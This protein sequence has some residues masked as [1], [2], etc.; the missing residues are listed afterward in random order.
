MLA[1]FVFI[2]YLF[3]ALAIPVTLA[4]A[5]VWRRTRAGRQVSCPGAGTAL[6]ALDPWHAMR[7]H[8]IGSAELRVRRCSRWPVDASGC[9]QDCLRPS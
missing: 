9:T 3:L 2:A 8:V 7:M 6:I 5:P 4:L 1:V